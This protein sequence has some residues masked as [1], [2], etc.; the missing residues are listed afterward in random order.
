MRSAKRLLAGRDEY[1]P[2]VKSSRSSIRSSVRGLTLSPPA[3][4]SLSCGF[5]TPSVY[6]G[7]AALGKGA[8]WDWEAREWYTYGPQD[9]G[10]HYD[11]TGVDFR[12]LMFLYGGG[13]GTGQPPAGQ[14]V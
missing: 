13:E 5:V 6:D 2:R 12:N 4:R 8:W 7:A 1:E 14:G 3:L 9:L 11:M 10:V